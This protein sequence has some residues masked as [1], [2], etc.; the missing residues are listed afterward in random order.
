VRLRS[1]G[2]GAG[3]VL[4]VGGEDPAGDDDHTAFRYLELEQWARQRFPQAGE[5]VQRFTGQA[6]PT[7][8]VFAFASHGECDSESVYIAT[9][10]WGTPMTR[11]AIAGL[12]VK[13]FV[14]GADMPWAELYMPAASYT[15]QGA[16]DLG[17]GFP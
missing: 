14:N 4:L 13:D 9:R 12:V 5:V 3:E 6:L 2:S 16:Q 17:R 7:L 10:E 1:H 15:R 8:D 11:G